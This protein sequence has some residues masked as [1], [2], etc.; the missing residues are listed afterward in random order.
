MIATCTLFALAPQ[1]PR[2]SSPS[3][4]S[5]WLGFLVNELPFV[6][7]YPLLVSTAL[8]IGQGDIYS[9]VGWVAFALPVLA[10]VGLGYVAWRALQA[11]PA[12]D[13]ALSE[14]LGSAWRAEL[15][16]ALA[17]SLRRRLP[18][19]RILFGPFFF[20]SRDVERL[21]N[22]SYGDAGKLNL[23]DVYRHRSHPSGCPTLVFLHG[24][25]FRSGKKNREARPLIYRLAGQGW[26][27]VSANYRLSPA[28][29]FPDHL[30]DVKRVIAWE[31]EHA[32]EYGAD[33]AVLFVAGSSAGGNLASM[34]A[35]T[36]NDST[37]QPGFEQADTSIIS[38][39]GYYGRHGSPPSSSPWTTSERMRRRSS[40]RAATRT[41]S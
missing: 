11:R 35:L 16:P 10:T 33:P 17:A 3:N 25:A 14:S 21:A 27:C 6:A 22:I 9:P 24:G 28:A 30:I 4:T 39:Y 23:L 29:Q 32:G 5:Y 19:A 40:S 13:H 36:P 12:L 41:R 7:F 15:D 20:R 18:S 38:L 2:R 31:R 37:F 26:L 34:A 1:R 8:A